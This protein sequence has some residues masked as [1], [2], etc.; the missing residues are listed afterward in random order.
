[1]G[2]NRI[3]EL[4]KEKGLTQA[5]LA[6]MLHLQKGTISM[7]ERGKRRPSFE[8]INNLSD[9]FDKNIGYILGFNNDSSSVQLTEE[10]MNFIAEAAICDDYNDLFRRFLM[11]DDYGQA[12]V[13]ELI[14]AEYMRC[15]DQKTT[16]DRKLIARCYVP[17]KK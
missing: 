9:I 2:D 5:E 16:L 11:L 14:R 4:R 1:M 12:A 13:E 7:W 3:K 17:R 10:D 6:E 8:M 15:C